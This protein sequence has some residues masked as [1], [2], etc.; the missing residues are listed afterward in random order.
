LNFNLIQEHLTK[1]Y[2]IKLS[3]NIFEKEFDG[4]I[5]LYTKSTIL[6]ENCIY[7]SKNTI[8]PI[9]NKINYLII[10]IGIP[11]DNILPENIIAIDEHANFIELYNYLSQL[12]SYCT[13]IH[14]ELYSSLIE[15]GELEP[16]LKKVSSIINN[17][18]YLMNIHNKMIAMA[19]DG[20]NT[21][22]FSGNDW[23]TKGSI[24][25]E[26]SKKIE[27]SHDYYT[28]F[29]VHGQGY[30]IAKEDSFLKYNYL[31]YNF[32]I[33]DFFS[34]RMVIYESNKTLT[35]LDKYVLNIL[36]EL[37]LN[38]IKRMDLMDPTK[39]NPLEIVLDKLCDGV[40]LDEDNLNKNLNKNNWDIDDNYY[41]FCFQLRQ[42]DFIYKTILTV[43]N[44]IEK[45]IRSSVV[46]KKDNKLC[47]VVR[48]NNPNEKEKTLTIIDKTLQQYA[49]HV[50]VSSTFK[51]IKNLKTYWKM[52][53]IALELQ[54]FDSKNHLHTFDNLIIN[55]LILKTCDDF[56]FSIL[57]P[58]GLKELILQ[59]KIHNS[60]LVETLKVYLSNDRKQKRS[61]QILAIH[62]S[63]FL[64]RLER[65]EEITNCNF[66][67][68]DQRILYLVLIRY[69]QQIEK[70]KLN[71]NN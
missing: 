70:E 18:I 64:S 20:T 4:Q 46:F 57:C 68:V 65:I 25:D 34:A 49:Y 60:G 45:N 59:D 5:I 3:K 44:T 2:D 69:F 7:I 37:T 54:D 41:C 42:T 51:G 1:K 8:P 39:K 11:T 14:N 32:F 63:T 15:T 29:N 16:L 71:D 35:Y 12:I 48:I 36:F 61:S 67:D 38:T 47:G 50:G 26:F 30:W 6:K 66:E 62:R 27:E 53:N 43:I 17:P 21:R 55:Y 23:L 31:F 24:S 13:Q 56:D 52:A 10:T 40:C 33:N 28:L 58:A 22:I 9:N 19:D